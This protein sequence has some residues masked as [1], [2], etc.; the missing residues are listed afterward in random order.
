MRALWGFA[1]LC[2]YSLP[3]GELPPPPPRAC[4]GREELIKKVVSLA[5]CLNPVALIGAGGIGK[6]PIAL[7]VLHSDRIKQWFGDNRR[8]IRCDQFTASR[9]NFLSRLSKVVGA[10]VENP[11]DLVSLRPSL[12]SEEIFLI[13]DNAESILDPHGTKEWEIYGLVEELSQLNNVCICITSCITIAPPYF[14]CLDVPTLSVDAAHSTFYRIYD[15]DEQSA[16]VYKILRQLDFHP[17]SVA[18]LATVAHQNKWSNDRLVK[19]WELHQ[20]GILQ[21]EHSKSLAITIELSLAPPPCSNNS[22]LMPEDF[23]ESSPSSPK[24]SM[25]TTSTGHFPPFPT[26]TPSS[27]SFAFSP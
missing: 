20:T 26:E 11:E 24:E 6:T 5:E 10:G 9:P 22:V 23:S 4:F 2:F 17:L 19:E 18:L 1:V 25:R 12:S 3:L 21:T 13:L 27:T 7:A 14:K 8:F 15:N 16:L